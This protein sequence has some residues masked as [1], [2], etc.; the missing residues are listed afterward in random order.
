M[1]LQ[2]SVLNTTLTG[3]FAVN[4]TIGDI[5]ECTMGWE[6]YRESKIKIFKRNPILPSL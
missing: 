1:G 3:I 2:I 5:H 6:E 4:D